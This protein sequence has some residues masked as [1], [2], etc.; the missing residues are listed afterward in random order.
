[1][2]VAVIV[3]ST[4]PNR[5]SPL[6]ASWVAEQALSRGDLTVEVVDLAALDLPMYD[7]PEPAAVA[8]ISGI[9]TQQWADLVDSFDA[10]VFVVPEYNHSFPAVVKN[11]IDLVFHQWN[12]KAVG[13][14]SYGLHGGVRAVEH[15]RGVTSEVKLASVR[16]QVVLSLFT[17]FTLTDM[18]QPGRFTP[19]P[20][21]AQSAQRMLDELLEWGGALKSLREKRVPV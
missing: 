12:D 3:G 8:R 20:H 10:Y 1:M 6:V 16:T 14:V 4:R 2:R 9:K 18:V 17:D 21:Q 13:F 15:L 19:G 11:A 7:E 5:R